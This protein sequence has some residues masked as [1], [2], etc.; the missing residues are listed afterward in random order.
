[1][2]NEYIKII[3]EAI[4]SGY[5]KYGEIFQYMTLKY[6]NNTNDFANK[7]PADNFSDMFKAMDT[8]FVA[9]ASKLDK[10]QFEN[11]QK[12]VDKFNNDKDEFSGEYDKMKHFIKGAYLGSNYG[13]T[14]GVIAGWGAEKID[15]LKYLKGELFDNRESHQI[16]FSWRDYAYTKAGSHLGDYLSDLN[17]EEALLQM[18]NF[19]SGSLNLGMIYTPSGIKEGGVGEFDPWFSPFSETTTDIVDDTIDIMMKSVK[20]AQPSK[21]LEQDMQCSIEPFDS[22]AIAQ[23]IIDTMFPYLVSSQAQSEVVNSTS[24]DNGLPYSINEYLSQF[25]SDSHENDMGRDID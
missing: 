5:E 6:L 13:D 19:S 8:Y 20:A 3:D 18:Q 15:S 12:V 17:Q 25:G 14:V 23:E 21:T 9:D 16:G 2:K 11:R 10:H 7:N 22:A 24:Y 4:D 1:M